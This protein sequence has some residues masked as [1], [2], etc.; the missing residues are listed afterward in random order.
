MQLLYTKSRSIIFIDII[1]CIITLTIV[2]STA[3]NPLFI[4]SDMKGTRFIVCNPKRPSI[5]CMNIMSRVNINL[6]IVADRARMRT[7]ASD[8]EKSTCRK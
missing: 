3:T 4:G 6:T 8:A 5:I 1:R 7:A 2:S